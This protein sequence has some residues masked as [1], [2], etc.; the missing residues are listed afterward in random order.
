MCN[1][2]NHMATGEGGEK[3][4][5]APDCI[6]AGKQSLEADHNGR[7]L[8]VTEENH[9]YFIPADA[10]PTDQIP[11][12]VSEITIDGKKLKVL[13]REVS[14]LERMVKNGSVIDITNLLLPSERRRR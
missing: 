12:L 9:A 2:L 8:W 11:G 1:L 7:V 13:P 4:V 6:T 10:K 5:I 3:I 14:E